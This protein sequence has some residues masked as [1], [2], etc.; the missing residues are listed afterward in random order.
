MLEEFKE[1]AIKGNVVDMSVGIIIGAAFTSVVTSLVED[2]LMPP[3]G[4]AMGGLDFAEKYA[5]LAAGD[6]AGPYTTLA[7]ARAAGATVLAYGS[8]VNSLVAFIIVAAVLF[9]A[10]RWMNRLRRP[11][12]PAAPTT[13]ACPHCR[14]SVDRSATR[15]AFCTS[16][17]EPVAEG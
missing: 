10:V 5:V 2:V 17:L 4:L 14:S 1:F 8:F 7:E 12:T 11:E 16:E 15:C 6:P 13:R 9:F 3:L